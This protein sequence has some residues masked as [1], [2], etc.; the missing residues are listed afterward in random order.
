MPAAILA[1]WGSILKRIVISEN[2]FKMAPLVTATAVTNNI[3]C[4]VFLTM[5]IYYNWDYVSES[6]EEDN[7][8]SEDDNEM[9]IPSSVLVSNANYGYIHI[10]QLL[11]A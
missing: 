6:S 3:S 10:I 1:F 4:H 5:T 2:C 11:R 9:D 7:V 8:S